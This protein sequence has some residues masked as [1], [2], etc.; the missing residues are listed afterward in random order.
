MKAPN[1]LKQLFLKYLENDMTQEEFDAFMDL[2]NER[3]EGLA[4]L[5][6]SHGIDPTELGK[7]KDFQQRPSP[8]FSN[9][10]LE[11]I[12]TPKR[13]PKAMWRPYFAIAATLIVLVAIGLG[14]FMAPEANTVN[15]QEVVAGK[16][17]P[18]KE[19]IV[20]KQADSQLKLVA[21]NGTLQIFDANGKVSGQQTGNTLSY[22][23]EMGA[24]EEK[25]AFNELTVPYG[26]TFDLQLSDGSHVKLNAGTTLKYPIR[27]LK[28]HPRQVYLEGEAYF[29]VAHDPKH[30]FTVH[31]NDKEVRV[32]GTAFNVSNFAEDGTTNTV[33]VSGSVALSNTD[34]T[35]P[36]TL[37]KPGQKGAW[38]HVDQALV[39]EAVDI[40][41]Y[42]A[43]TKNQM[44]LKKTAF[45]AIRKKL[46]RKHNVTIENRYGL[47]DVQVY[48]VTFGDESIEEILEA[49]ME[50]IPFDYQRNENHIIITAT[51]QQNTLPM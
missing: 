25:L 49:F 4:Q 38:H 41:L 6:D 24:P 14:L 31:V 20:L 8:E 22:T 37:L 1:D 18:G 27:F 45:G 28:D 16:N 15:T 19:N 35:G 3:P 47:L 51:T 17:E 30:P 48:T 50:D 33:L 23:Q 26:K 44:I 32:L 12:A 11:T 29:E 10:L 36:D 34:A 43:W 7:R 40:D 13:N 9:R 21:E 5:I 42:T 39:V 46:E 2:I